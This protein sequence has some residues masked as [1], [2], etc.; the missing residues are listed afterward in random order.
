MFRSLCPLDT[1]NYG[2][3][4]P[5]N[6]VYDFK[7]GNM[8][9]RDRSHITSLPLRLKFRGAWG[10]EKI[11]TFI[12]SGNNLWLHVAKPPNYDAQLSIN[13]TGATKMTS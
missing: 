1:A 9:A 4:R 2:F 8:F 13:C 6:Q 3:L 12:T 11:G 5:R 7:N 10:T